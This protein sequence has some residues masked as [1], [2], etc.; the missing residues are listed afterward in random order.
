MTLPLLF[1]T[2]NPHLSLLRLPV[3]SASF[4][5]PASSRQ[6]DL[7]RRVHETPPG[8]EKTVFWVSQAL[9]GGIRSCNLY[10]GRRRV[11]KE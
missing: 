1:E 7:C 9:E 5:L 8:F 6:N 10:Y 3:T 4:A 2:H 11:R